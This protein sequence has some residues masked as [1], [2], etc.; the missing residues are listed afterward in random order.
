MA[1]GS[2]TSTDRIACSQ[3]GVNMQAGGSLEPDHDLLSK[4]TSTS[5]QH[6]VLISVGVSKAET[7]FPV[8]H[9]LQKLMSL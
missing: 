8:G 6:G 2:V 5:D 7:P 3:A 4:T 1:L 9:Y